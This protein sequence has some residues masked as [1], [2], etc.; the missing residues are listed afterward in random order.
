MPP[1]SRE[2]ISPQYS[3]FTCASVRPVLLPADHHHVWRL[4]SFTNLQTLSAKVQPPAFLWRVPFKVAGLQESAG[5]PS[6]RCEEQSSKGNVAV[7]HLQPSTLDSDVSKHY[8]ALPTSV[9]FQCRLSLWD[10]WC[11]P[12]N[13]LLRSWNPVPKA[14]LF[15]RALSLTFKLHILEESEKCASFVSPKG[16]F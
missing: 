13:Q 14:V 4:S 2:P 12:P 5:G 3:K 6:Q 10:R 9:S 16:S 15:N 11:F 7:S 8:C 1:E